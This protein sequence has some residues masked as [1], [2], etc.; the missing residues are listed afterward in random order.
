MRWPA[1]V[2]L[3]GA[4]LLSSCAPVAGAAAPQGAAA[5]ALGE[6]FTLAAGGTARVGSARVGVTFE[7]VVTDS[8]CPVDVQCI[9]AGEAIVRVAVAAPGQAAETVE[10]QTTPSRNQ[11]AVAGYLLTL[12]R[13]LPEPNTKERHTPSDYRATFTLAQP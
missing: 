11:A 9:R 13:L 12:T 6:P 8:R 10:I 2:P 1:L 3:F 7:A 5:V 4:L